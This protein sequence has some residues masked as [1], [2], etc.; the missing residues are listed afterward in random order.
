MGGVCIKG[1]KRNQTSVRKWVEYAYCKGEKGKG[2]AD[3]QDLYRYG[4]RLPRE[5]YGVHNKWEKAEVWI[6]DFH[7]DCSSS[8]SDRERGSL[9]L[10]GNML[11]IFETLRWKVQDSGLVISIQPKQL[12][13]HMTLRLSKCA[14]PGCSQLPLQC[15]LRT[16]N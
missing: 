12:Q 1:N 6:I 2:D 10:T 7:L 8:F 14:V 13:R 5:I 9:R 3:G 11:H 4:H 16:V 15:R